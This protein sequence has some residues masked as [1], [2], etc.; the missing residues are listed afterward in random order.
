M[1]RTIEY[2]KDI[3]I[4]TFFKDG[5]YDLQSVRRNANKPLIAELKSVKLGNCKTYQEKIYRIVN[6]IT[7]DPSCSVCCSQKISFGGINAGYKRSCSVKCASNDPVVRQKTKDTL[8][9]RYGGSHMSNK[10][11]MN[12]Y[13]SALSEAGRA[14]PGSFGSKENKDAIMAKYGVEFACQSPRVI[15]RIQNTMIERYGVGNANQVPQFKAKSKAT[16]IRNNGCA[17]GW[18]NKV[19]QKA[20]LEKYGF[21][22]PQQVPEIAA[23]SRETHIRNN[24]GI[25]WQILSVQRAGYEA[26]GRIK[27]LLYRPVK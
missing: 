3:V 7:T 23:K 12:S 9:E 6:C 21:A 5:E 14:W 17:M 20:M 26:L 8:N 1:N 18:N 4:A 24:G 15:G 27:I 13:K 11:W 22:N 25:G 2:Y 16:Y 10:Q 19:M